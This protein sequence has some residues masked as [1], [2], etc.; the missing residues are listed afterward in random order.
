MAAAGEAEIFAMHLAEDGAAGIED[1][2]DDGG[3]GVGD[4]AFERRG[5]VH[6]GNAG[7]AD[8]VFERDGLA[9]EL[10]ARG[11]LDRGLDVPG[12][13]LV[14]FALGTVT[15]RPRVFHGG[16]LIPR[17]LERGGGGVNFSVRRRTVWEPPFFL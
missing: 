6:H 12:V 4:V 3:V 10:A 13:E 1:A 17:R 8:I 5:A 9:G 15:R 16:E 14:F 2:G 11:T 7:E